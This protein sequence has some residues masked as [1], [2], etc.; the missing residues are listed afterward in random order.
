MEPGAL[1]YTVGSPGALLTLAQSL[2]TFLEPWL[3][4]WGGGG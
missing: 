2:G 1:H 3:A 4:Q